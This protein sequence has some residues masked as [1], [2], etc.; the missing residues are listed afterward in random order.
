MDAV[1]KLQL[2]T[3]EARY[4]VTDID[5]Q[6][7]VYINKKLKSKQH[8]GFGKKP[9]EENMPVFLCISGWWKKDT[10]AENFIGIGM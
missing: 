5:V 1:Q 4:E 9:D 2:L 8:T 6:R 7:Q 3:Q 10:P